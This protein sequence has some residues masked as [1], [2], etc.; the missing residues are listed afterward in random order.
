MKPAQ[1]SQQTQLGELCAAPQPILPAGTVLSGTFLPTLSRCLSHH[2]ICVHQ[3]LE[4]CTGTS[5]PW[6]RGSLGTALGC[7]LQM[8]RP[9]RLGSRR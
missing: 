6:S 5:F 8:R 3:Q 1:Y 4:P 9:R 7:A 2:G